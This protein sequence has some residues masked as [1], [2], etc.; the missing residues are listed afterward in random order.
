[1]IDMKLLITG[2]TDLVGS[3]LQKVR[4]DTIYVSSK[5]CDLTKEVEFKAMFEKYISSN[6][7]HLAARVGGIVNNMNHPAEF[8]YQNV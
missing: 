1:M 4:L 2:G 5:D 8:I 7:I 6:V 3:A